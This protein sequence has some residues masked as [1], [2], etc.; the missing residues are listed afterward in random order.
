[1]HLIR[2][3]VR[4]P[5]VMVLIIMVVLTVINVLWLIVFIIDGVMS[6]IKIQPK[7]ARNTKKRYYAF[8]D[9]DCNSSIISYIR[10]NF[11]L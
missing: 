3:F 2:V 7:S 1:M 10:R 9:M 11:H 8:L 4:F 6:I 5:N